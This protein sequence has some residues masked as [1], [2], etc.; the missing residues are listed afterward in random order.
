LGDICDPDDDNDGICDIGESDISCTG[1]DNCP[2]VTN[3]G[4]EDYELDGLGDACDPDD[5]NDGIPDDVEGN[6]DPDGDGIPNWF[7][8]D[9]DN[10]SILD[11]VDNC[12]FVTNA[13][14]ADG[15]DDEVGDSCDNCLS[16][17]NPDQDDYDRDGLGDRC[18]NCIEMPNGPDSGVC[19]KT[20]G[21]IVES[22]GV[23][24]TSDGECEINETC[25]MQQ[26]DYNENG[27]GDV[28][29]CYADFDGDGKV[30]PSDVMI[31]FME[32]RRKDCSEENPCQA[33][34]DRDGK[35]YPNDWLIL[36]RE[37][38]RNDCPVSLY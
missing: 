4:Q 35:V 30:Y 26:E 13:N 31:L 12:Q 34:I 7:D 23:N 1:S 38:K 33:D 11:D 19:A 5:D 9:S 10:D 25:L 16:D 32:L 15:D 3:P 18:D 20:R 22:K 6:G 2:Y 36:I 24:C 21:I 8:A 29:E 37:Y 28:C 17:Y 27:I 14:Q